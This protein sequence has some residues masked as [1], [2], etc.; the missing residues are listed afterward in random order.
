LTKDFQLVYRIEEEDIWE[1]YNFGNFRTFALDNCGNM[2]VIASSRNNS[3][4]LLTIDKTGKL[5][6]TN[7]IDYYKTI[8]SSIFNENGNLIFHS[9]SQEFPFYRFDFDNNKIEPMGK[10]PEAKKTSIGRAGILQKDINGNIVIVYENYPSYM[11]TYSIKG[12]L[13][14]EINL[15]KD[16][17]QPRPDLLTR[18]LDFTIEPETNKIF[19]L[20]NSSHC[21]PRE[22]MVLDTTGNI[23]DNYELPPDTRRICAA[24]DNILYSSRTQFNIIEMIIK[25]KLYSAVTNLE[26]Y[27]L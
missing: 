15:D 7:Y 17:K 23:K 26:V 4:A 25:L 11:Q 14:S 5:I 19:L 9:P 3:T 24:K 13:I 10:Y 16:Q 18:I 12:E 22:I 21:S 2:L 20:K 27:K 1:K 6:K 8:E